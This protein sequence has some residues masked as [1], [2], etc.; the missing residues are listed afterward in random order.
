[1]ENENKFALKWHIYGLDYGI[2]VEIDEWLKKGHPVIVNVSR[3][4]IQEAKNIYMN[5]KVIFI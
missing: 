1:M 3:T 5:L 2:P 4:I